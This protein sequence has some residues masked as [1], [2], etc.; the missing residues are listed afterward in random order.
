MEQA[1]G[2]LNPA[3]YLAIILVVLGTLAY[4][5]IHYIWRARR[6]DTLPSAPLAVKPKPIM[7]DAE[8]AFFHTLQNAFANRYEIF[9]QVALESLVSQTGKLPANVWGML[10]NSRVDFV[11]AH[12]KF[13]GPLAVLELDDSSHAQATTRA[14]DEI[15]ERILKDAKIP[16]LRFRVG[17][18]WDANVI[19]AQ[20]E[21]IVN[22]SN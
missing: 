1:L 7:T 19:R 6:Q 2:A 13:L 18:K 9:P 3:I 22:V 11:L 8:R 20:V 21:Q 4:F 16:L 17:D 15:K 12:P 10:R 14:R 5:V